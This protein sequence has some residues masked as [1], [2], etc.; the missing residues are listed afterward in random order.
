[1][2]GRMRAGV[3]LVVAYSVLAALTSDASSADDLFG[4]GWVPSLAIT[5]GASIQRQSGFQYSTTTDGET[6]ITSPL[7]TPAKGDRDEAA[8]AF[9]GGALELLTPA[10]PLP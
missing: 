10:L 7:R 3:N 6:N 5:S 9:V 2:Y 4:A 8:S 1:S